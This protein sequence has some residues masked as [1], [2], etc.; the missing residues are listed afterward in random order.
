MSNPNIPQVFNPQME[1][2]A[3][4][5][6]AID[7]G[8]KQV[9]NG[10]WV[11][12]FTLPADDP[13]NVYCKE[14][15]YVEIFDEK[16][17]IELFRIVKSTFT[18]SRQGFITYELEHVITTLLDN[19]LFKFHQIGNIGVFTQEVINYVLSF[20]RSK[21]GDLGVATSGTNFFTNGKTIIF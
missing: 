15:N 13:K 10:L 8:Y 5:D 2:L 11:A 6:K 7:I 1:R 3:A 12:K 9:F 17:R 20:Q 16:R 14:F 18:R 21:I 4:L 19:V